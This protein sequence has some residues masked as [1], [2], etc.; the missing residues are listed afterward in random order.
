MNF[1][2][3]K[4]IQLIYIIWFCR[5]SVEWTHRDII[6][7]NLQQRDQKQFEDVESKCSNFKMNLSHETKTT[8][9]LIFFNFSS[10]FN[11]Y[12]LRISIEVEQM[13]ITI[14]MSFEGRLR[15]SKFYTNWIRN[16]V[17]N[18]L[19]HSNHKTNTSTNPDW[20]F[21]LDWS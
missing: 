10:P 13:I 17:L 7:P 14:L 1:A 9:L 20:Y 8:I 15:C 18:E 4:D 11:R 12:H 6:L 3:S 21:V 16:F 5:K 19:D 2:F